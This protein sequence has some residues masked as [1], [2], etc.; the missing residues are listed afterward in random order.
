MSGYEEIQHGF[1]HAIL[2]TMNKAIYDHSD[3]IRLI[4]RSMGGGG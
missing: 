1:R 4:G 3:V 2:E